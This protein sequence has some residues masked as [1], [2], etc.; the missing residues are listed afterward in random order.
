MYYSFL[1]LLFKHTG[2]SF[3]RLVSPVQC[4]VVTSGGSMDRAALLYMLLR[5]RFTSHS[6][7]IQNNILTFIN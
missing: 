6:C 5:V 3:Y 4:S 1:E 7:E 2:G